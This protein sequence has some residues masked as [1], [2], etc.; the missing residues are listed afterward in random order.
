MR[1]L[2]VG[3]ALALFHAPHSIAGELTGT[4]KAIA[5]RGSFVIGYREAEP[6][7]SFHDK[8]AAPIG[9]S[10]DLCGHVA[11]AIKQ[12]LGRADIATEYVAVTAN[13]RF[14]AIQ[15]GRIDI[16][17]G[18]TTKTLGRSERVDFSQ[19]TFV[20]GAGLLSRDG[21]QV[22]NLLGLQGRKVAV[23]EATTTIDMLQQ[24]LKARLVDAEVVAV[25]SAAEG[26]AMLDAGT[27]DA[28]SSDQVVLIG[29]VLSRPG[30]QKY[31]L[32]GE[33][34]SFEPFALAVRR[35][36]ADFRLVADRALAALYRNKQIRLIY[37]KWFGRFAAKVPN[38]LKA[39]YK[40]GATPE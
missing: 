26:M 10:I 3:L 19:L 36:D 8:N 9:Y 15:S 34:Y 21:D 20:T 2:T 18:A 13:N 35:N 12:K 25:A 29:L 27:V 33:L 4:L 16:L 17:C 14:D 39:V 30:E 6:P 32:S 38:L 37:K 23:V 24:T 28:F 1:L 5:E 11:A 40:M 31:F 7:M 22:A